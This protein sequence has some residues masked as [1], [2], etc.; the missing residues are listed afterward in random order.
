MNDIIVLLNKPVNPLNISVSLAYAQ[1]V[2]E[3]QQTFVINC[4]IFH[5]LNELAIVDRMGPNG[6]RKGFFF[7]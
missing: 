7:F 1:A 4:S 6:L 3:V 2:Y 5:Q